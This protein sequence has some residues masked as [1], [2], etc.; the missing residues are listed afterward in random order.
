M[1]IKNHK[2]KDKDSYIIDV[3]D[4]NAYIIF[5]KPHPNRI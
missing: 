3:I 4:I 5:V 1:S 2:S